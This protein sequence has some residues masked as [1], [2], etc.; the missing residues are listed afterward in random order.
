MPLYEYQCD[1]CRQVTTILVRGQPGASMPTCRRCGGSKLTK[2]ISRFA[3]HRSWGD[4]L[5]WVPSRETLTDVDEDDPH[6]M[7]Q[8]MG[9]MQQ[10]MGG[11][12]SPDFERTRREL[13]DDGD[14]LDI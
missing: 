12:V 10:E 11:E 2:L 4:S 3:F 7:D 1:D 8:F 6:S 5:D 13:A 9:R 14:D